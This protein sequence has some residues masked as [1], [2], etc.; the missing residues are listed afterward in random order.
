[1][2][3]SVE[4]ILLQLI[5]KVTPSPIIVLHLVHLLPIHHRHYVAPASMTHCHHAACAYVA[6]ASMSHHHH[7]ACA[8][9]A[10]SII[11]IYP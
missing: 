9:A 8:Y 1:M 10:P 3:R 7:A 11:M 5:L 4:D 6:P 2:M